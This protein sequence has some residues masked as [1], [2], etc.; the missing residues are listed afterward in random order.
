MQ[1][2]PG[3]FHGALNRGLKSQAGSP[4]EAY[5]YFNNPDALVQLFDS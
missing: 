3:S 4:E 1:A 5:L 2:D